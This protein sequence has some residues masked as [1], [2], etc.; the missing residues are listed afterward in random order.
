MKKILP[1]LLLVLVL[2]SCSEYQKVLK[3]QDIKAKYEMAEKFYNE[4]DFK[5]ANRLFEQI[6]P[7]YVGKPQGER[8]MFFNANSYYEIRMYNDA[9]YHFERFI[10]AYP[11]SEKV[12]E[13]S[14]MGAKSYAHLSRNYSLD[15]TDTDKALLKMQNFINTYPDS[16]YLAE[17]NEIAAKLITKKEKKSIEI[18]KQF[19]K[20]GEFYD[21]EYSI[22]AIKAL[23]NFMIDNPGSIYKE[24]ALYYKTLAAYNLAINSHPYKKEE[25]LKNANEAYGKLMKTFPETEF[26]KKANNMKEKIDKELQNYSK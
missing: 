17:A 18:A 3:N 7:K 2:G 5:R 1:L 11:R 21:L 8:V 15:Q 25:R 9:G 12:Q 20:L 10:K 19:T 22:S 24:E 13:A 26:A 14:F 16:E 6:T 23:E 4:G